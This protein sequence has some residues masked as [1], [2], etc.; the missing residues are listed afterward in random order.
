MQAIR[1]KITAA[2]DDHELAFLPALDPTKKLMVR[3]SGDEDRPESANA[4][5]NL[6][7]PSDPERKAVI[8]AIGQVVASY[9]SEKSLE[10]RLLGGEDITVFPLCSVL[11]QE[12]IGE[13]A[14]AIPCSFVMYSK[15]SGMDT[16]GLVHIQATYGH[17]EGIV[18]SRV[19]FDSYYMSGGHL[20][21]TT[22]A[23][24]PVRLR[25]GEGSGLDIVTNSE[26]IADQPVLSP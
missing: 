19:P 7:L 9:F 23:H 25:K 21:S 6:S 24:K 12:L 10:Q 18:E 4:G 3:S 13:S 22:I 5:G 11:I 15:E 1:D 20:T 26:T 16:A 8:H 14:E 17:G 2:F